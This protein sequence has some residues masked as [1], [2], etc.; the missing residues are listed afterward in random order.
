MTTHMDAVVRI[1]RYLKG[2]P[3]RGLRMQKNKHIKIMH[4]SMLTGQAV[5]IENRPVTALF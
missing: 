3:R 1:L 2:S 5:V 4:A